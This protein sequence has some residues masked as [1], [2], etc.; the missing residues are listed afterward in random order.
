MWIKII[1][2]KRFGYSTFKEACEDKNRIELIFDGL[3]Y[4]ERPT[5]TD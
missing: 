2:K 3:F 5:T 1:D 4:L